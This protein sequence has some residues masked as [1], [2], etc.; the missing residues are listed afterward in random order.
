MGDTFLW[1]MGVIA[2]PSELGPLLDTT[3]SD[4]GDN[5][6]RLQITWL[7]PNETFPEHSFN[8]MMI[9]AENRA[10]AVMWCRLVRAM[11]Q[12]IASQIL[13]VLPDAEQ[14]PD[15]NELATLEIQDVYQ[16]DQ[17]NARFLRIKISAC[18][19]VFITRRAEKVIQD[20]VSTT[21]HYFGM[22]YLN[23]LTG[24]LTQA[25]DL[26]YIMIGQV[27]PDNSRQLKSLVMRR[28]YENQEEVSFPISDSPCV[29][30]LSSGSMMVFGNHV[31]VQFPRDHFLK[32]LG[33]QSFI[34][35]PIFNSEGDTLGLLIAMDT[36]AIPGNE[37]YIPIFEFLARRVGLELERE[38]TLQELSRT[39]DSLEIE[40]AKRT[41]DLEASHKKL[42]DV[43]H[44]AG[45]AEIATG[46]LHNIGNLLNSIKIAGEALLTF[47]DSNT[48]RITRKIRE[49][50]AA[51]RDQLPAYLE[52]HPKGS[53]LPDA[54]LTIFDQFERELDMVEAE[55]RVIQ[56][57]VDT[58]IRIV[59]AQQSNVHREPFVEHFTLTEV[60]HDSV[61]MLSL[62]L[63]KN[64]VTVHQDIHAELTIRAQRSKLE[65]VCSNLIKN[66]VE[67]MQANNAD[68]RQIHISTTH[69]DTSIQL[70]MKDNGCGMSQD[71]QNNIFKFGYT[72]KRNGHGFGLHSS[73][74]LV[75][76]MGGSITGSSDG[77]GR[78]SAFVIT[79]P[80]AAMAN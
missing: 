12:N 69:D 28:R 48:L 40:V 1:H 63:E 31:S 29:Q 61:N 75:N 65:Q 57:N 44:E 50:V 24:Y 55:G 6:H 19:K 13:L 7:G 38:I 67:A 17:I 74:L 33:I 9:Y 45:K 36:Q 23:Y 47:K 42:L 54:F 59:Q 64:S 78:G 70:V 68:A 8:I 66:A 80:R 73:I 26:E 52:N 56:R 11:R 76:S 41:A 35:T 51:N 27:D 62:E 15:E 20:L 60:I 37:L 25:L 14:C 39:K 49:I 16:R 58:I 32:D 4:L 2:D 3:L 46:I 30:V 18:L 53:H 22:D 43:A 79:L 5:Q 21:Q 71:T 77:E 34:G 72:T 10:E